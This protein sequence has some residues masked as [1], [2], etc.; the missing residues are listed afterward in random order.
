MYTASYLVAMKSDHYGICQAGTKVNWKSVIATILYSKILIA[1]S[2]IYKSL[3]CLTINVRST[4]D[5][6]ECDFIAQ[7]LQRRKEMMHVDCFSRRRQFLLLT[8]FQMLLYTC[9]KHTCTNS[10]EKN[11]LETIMGDNWVI[12]F[13]FSPLQI[14]QPLIRTFK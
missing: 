2:F 7:N 3:S 8:Y 6:L 13:G 9:P 10:E 12:N 4:N 14:N 1:I 11:Q 5:S